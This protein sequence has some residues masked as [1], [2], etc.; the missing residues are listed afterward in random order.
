MNLLV[1]TLA[2]LHPSLGT[3]S[4]VTLAIFLLVLV[5]TGLFF[6]G[7]AVK[8]TQVVLQLSKAI[9]G[10]K[11]SRKDGKAPK[12]SS[13]SKYFGDEPLRHLWEEYTDTLHEMKYASNSQQSLVEVRATVPS[14]T[15]F[16]REVL[17]DSR[18]FD[19]FTKHLPGVL[20]GLGII[21]TFAGLLEGLGKFDPSS[22]ASAV[23]G[24]RPLLDGVSHAFVASGTAIGCAMVVVF[25]SRLVL[26]YCYRLV[27]NLS[28]GIDSLYSTGAGEEYLARLV[29]ATE[30][31]EAN[32]AQLK[33][34][35]VE[36]LRKMMQ[37]LVE[38]QIV[39]HQA[40]TKE[41]GV[42]LANTISSVMAE[43]IQKM[44]E[45]INTT[46]T[47][48]GAQVSGMLESLLTGF[49][50]KLE[51]TF[52][53]QMRGINDQM[54][55]SMEVMTSVQAALQ[56]LLADIKRTNEQASNTLTG[57]LEEAMKKAADN[58]RVLIEQMREFVQ[59]FKKLVEDERS[60]SKQA[61]DDAMSKVLADLSA[62]IKNM[63]A[64]RAG[65][66][67]AEGERQVRL[68]E[69]TNIL[70]NNLSSQINELLKAVADQVTKTQQ[71]IHAIS[72]VS[73]RA[74]DGM[75]QGALTMASAADRFHTAGNS[76]TG[77]IEKTAR[78]SESLTSAAAALQSSAQAVHRG[79]EQYE[80]TRKTVDSQVTTLMGLIE[81]AK[82]EAGVSKELIESIEASAAALKNAESQSREHLEQVNSALVEAFNQFGSALV[83]QV[84][85]S[86]KETDAHMAAGMGQ[87]SGVVQGLVQAVQRMTK[88]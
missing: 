80:N 13:L 88:A 42:S 38:R 34:A 2:R 83:E 70:F 87:L 76:V 65:A 9:K 28:H 64:I 46:T 55:R 5:L 35:L 4:G 47:N 81:S 62:A 72:D 69:G 14:E 78:L 73:T 48:N 36:D 75:N 8:G 66:A 3:L 7:Y 12:P 41:L 21:G 86:V 54:Q 37:E 17:V 71:N 84:R 1:E 32:T 23:S 33:D 25:V 61:L 67:Q 11:S 74:V 16:T 68:T 79:F 57:T 24:L 52:G 26:A 39:S 31:S 82:K 27:E 85:K 40:A 63:E 6:I 22:T 51:D 56:E 77:V 18:L 30:Q 20:T 29:K 58:Q 53:G 44:T 59:E 15:L 50:A 60:K 43:P 45:A 10:I 49:M 19:D